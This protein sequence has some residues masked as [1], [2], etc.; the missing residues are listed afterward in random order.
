[1]AD[2]TLSHAAGGQLGDKAAWLLSH[3]ECVPAVKLEL[4]KKQAKVKAARAACHAG[5]ACAS[6]Q[7]AMH[8]A[9]R[10]HVAGPGLLSCLNLMFLSIA[11]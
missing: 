10:L 6:Q 3:A 1:M 9:Q 11:A 7:H 2:N 4:D 8:E 5:A